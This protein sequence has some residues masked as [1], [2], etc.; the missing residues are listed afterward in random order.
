MAMAEE[1]LDRGQIATGFEQ[2]R[3]EGVAQRVDPALL[4]DAR[5]ELGHRVELLG[6]GDIDR[7]RALAILKEPDV[8][9]PDAPV[10]APVLEQPRGERPGAI[11]A[12]FALA[13]VDRQAVGVEVRDLEGDDLADAET[14]GVGGRQQEAMPGMRA[15][16]QEAPDFFPAQDIGQLLGLAGRRHVEGRRLAPEGHVVEEAEGVAGLGARTP[17][18]RAL[19]E[20]Q[21]D[22]RLHLVGREL[23][24]GPVVVAGQAYHLTDVRL[25]GSGGK[26][27]TVMSRIIRSRSSLMS[28]LRRESWDGGDCERCFRGRDD[29]HATP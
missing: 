25:V 12:A 19:A 26:P 7:T 17:R 5:P 18:A 21:R 3:G 8:R 1:C 10:G 4:G 23:V 16:A 24:G 27:R 2:V 29:D 15:G 9:G 14:T 11:L 20:H 13:D 6:D 22:V 28:H